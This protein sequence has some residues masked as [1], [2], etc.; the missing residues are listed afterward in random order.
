[1]DH[2]KY[3]DKALASNATTILINKKVNCPPGKALLISDDPFRDFNKLVAHFSPA[4]YSLKQISDTAS[5]GKNTI[6]MPGVY[7]GNNVRVG[8][9]CVIHPNVVIYNNCIIGN[10]V[11]IHSGSVIGSDAFY[12]KKRPD[13]YERLLTCGR[14]VIHDDVEIGALCT[15]DRGVSG[16][17]VIGKGTKMDRH[18]QIGHDTVI[19]QM[20]LFASQVGISGVVTVEDNVTLWGQVGVPSNLRIGKG[21]VVLGQAGLVKDLEPGKTYFGSPAIEAREKMRE[22]A[23]IKKIP[24]LIE[25]LDLYNKKSKSYE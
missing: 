19:G 3:Y 15:I 8:N 18:V 14:V 17:T 6:I 22:I 9:D 11:I 1:V 21:A 12:Y 10:N 16:D 20:C 5:I 13:K 24:E 25:H 7:L 23:L 4:T 2:P